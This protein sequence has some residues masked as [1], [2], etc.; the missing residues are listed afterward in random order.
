VVFKID[1]TGE[2]VIVPKIATIHGERIYFK[3]YYNKLDG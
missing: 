2:K 1:D 3:K